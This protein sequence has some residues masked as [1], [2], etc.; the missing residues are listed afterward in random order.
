MRHHAL[1]DTLHAHSCRAGL[2]AERERAGL[3]PPKPPEEGGSSAAVPSARRPADVWLPRGPSGRGVAIDLAVTSGLRRVI[4]SQ[5]A[6]DATFVSTQYED[7][8]RSYLDTE[9][10][11]SAAGFDFAPFI[12]E[13]HGGGSG[14]VARRLIAFVASSASALAGD[15]VEEEAA[16]LAGGLSIALMRESARSIVRRLASPPDS[17]PSACPAGWEEPAHC[18]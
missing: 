8:K 13:A 7:H 18:T 2:R 4:V 5:S 12:L 10:Q 15:G 16:R 11:C 6:V 17:T 9:A 3:L 1:R 14:A